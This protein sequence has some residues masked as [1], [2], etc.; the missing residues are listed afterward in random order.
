MVAEHD[1]PR[2]RAFAFDAAAALAVATTSTQ[3]T[4]FASPVISKATQKRLP[5]RAPWAAEN[6]EL[7]GSKVPD[8]HVALQNGADNHDSYGGVKEISRVAGLALG[9]FLPK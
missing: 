2:T 6:G 7:I 4:R 8:V 9:V 1:A 5:E 3:S